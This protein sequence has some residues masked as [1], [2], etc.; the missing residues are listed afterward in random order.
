MIPALFGLLGCVDAFV[1]IPI[2]PISTTVAL[3][4][5][6]VPA[7]LIA[8]D[9]TLRAVACGAASPCPQPAA[10]AVTLACVDS[11]C[12]LSPFVLRATTADLDLSAYEVYRDYADALES[13]TVTAVSVRLTGAAVGN[14][15]GPLDVW[16]T[17][18][19]GSDA[20]EHHLGASLRTPLARSPVDVPVVVDAV[21]V[22][23]LVA[24]VMAGNTRLRLR[25]EG[26]LDVGTGALPAAQVELATTLL[27]QVHGGL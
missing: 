8:A 27:L 6:G 2:G 22:R 25:L 3:P 23:A 15:V 5:Q 24:Y 19:A 11:V 16:W 7:A 17:A 13:L 10:A 21:G 4:V 26:P 12:A 20:T 9:G 14:A 18:A 1:A